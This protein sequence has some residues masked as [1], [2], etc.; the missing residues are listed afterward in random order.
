MHKEE[1]MQLWHSNASF[2]VVYH[3]FGHCSNS[4]VILASHWL[5]LCPNGVQKW[6]GDVDQ[7]FL[8]RWNVMT[9]AIKIKNSHKIQYREL[10]QDVSHWYASNNLLFEKGVFIDVPVFSVTQWNIHSI[11]CFLIFICF[12]DLTTC[13][14]SQTWENVNFKLSVLLTT[15]NLSS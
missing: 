3:I 6:I 13:F 10:N 4:T 9:K 5:H 15:R 7:W 1:Q 8:H 14:D 12:K 11:V 2:C